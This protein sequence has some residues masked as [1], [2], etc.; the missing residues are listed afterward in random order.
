MINSLNLQSVSIDLELVK[1]SGTPKT[2]PGEIKVTKPLKFIFFSFFFYN[3][4]LNWWKE[5]CVLGTISRVCRDLIYYST[6]HELRAT[7][8][9]PTNVH[10]LIFEQGM[11]C[12]FFHARFFQTSFVQ[13]LFCFAQKFTDFSD[14][15]DLQEFFRPF[16]L[17]GLG[18]CNGWLQKVSP[19]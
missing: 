3:K 14:N 15:I 18:L 16:G 9:K 11:A 13:W 8:K 5:C 7:S 4:R 17:S 19:P 1:I 6:Q 10:Y 12:F 2:Y